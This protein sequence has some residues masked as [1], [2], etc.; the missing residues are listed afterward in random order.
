MGGKI[1]NLL[2]DIQF[3]IVDDF[4]VAVLNFFV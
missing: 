2:S 1:V 4:S 3:E